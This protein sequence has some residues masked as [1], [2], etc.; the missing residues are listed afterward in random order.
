M[1]STCVCDLTVF[2]ETSKVSLQMELHTWK[3][4]PPFSGWQE[5]INKEQTWSVGDLDAFGVNESPKG[6]GPT[7]GTWD[8]DQPPETWKLEASPLD[9][10]PGQ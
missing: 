6:L 2:V 9:N 4:P 3:S 7:T 1:R 5:D 8:V 10:A